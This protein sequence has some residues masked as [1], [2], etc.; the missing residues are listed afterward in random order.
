MSQVVTCN[1][2]HISHSI[3]FLSLTGYGFTGDRRQAAGRHAGASDSGATIPVIKS[4]VKD[5]S[6]CARG[7]TSLS[8]FHCLEGSRAEEVL[9]EAAFMPSLRELSI[10][11]SRL[12]TS[13]L[14]RLKASRSLESLDARCSDIGDE[15]IRVISQISRITCLQLTGCDE[16]SERVSA[17]GLR[18]LR[19]MVT[20]GRLTR[21]VLS[22]RQH[23]MARRLL[24]PSVLECD[25]SSVCTAEDAAARFLQVPRMDIVVSR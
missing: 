12:P 16:G 4:I 3:L 14:E 7:L 22:C 20:K 1:V 10:G 5:I 25:V 23:N 8:L 18:A 6:V 2:Q 19:E 15:H 17:Q 9:R 13:A 11:F 21:L 24:P